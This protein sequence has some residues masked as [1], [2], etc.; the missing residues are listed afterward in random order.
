MCQMSVVLEDGKEETLI[1]KNVA[2]LVV[3]PAGVQ[4]SSMFERPREIQD[5]GITRI[6]FLGGKVYLTAT[7]R[8]SS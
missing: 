1:V 8:D 3:T 2:E 6:D 4:V 5:V 7:K